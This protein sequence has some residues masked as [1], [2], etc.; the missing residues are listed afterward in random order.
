ME[1][2]REEKKHIAGTFLSLYVLFHL[3]YL[4]FLN[5][6][7]G[8]ALGMRDMGFAVC[9]LAFAVNHTFSYFHNRQ[10]DLDRIPDV[11]TFMMY[12]GLR[13]VPMLGALG[14][15]LPVDDP[16]LSMLQFLVLKG[17]ID[18]IMHIWQHAAMKAKP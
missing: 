12:P 1:A 16:G 3:M 9:I 13:S 14:T 17:L 6:V 18:V 5:G 4:V 11:S 10:E 2:T 7:G 15:I 8:S